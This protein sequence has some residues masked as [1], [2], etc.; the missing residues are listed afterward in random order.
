MERIS[1]TPDCSGVEGSRHNFSELPVN[2]CNIVM[3]M[4]EMGSSLGLEVDSAYQRTTFDSWTGS[5]K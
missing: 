3:Y 1:C 5:E 4:L 2:R